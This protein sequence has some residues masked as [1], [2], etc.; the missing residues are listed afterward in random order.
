MVGLTGPAVILGCTNKISHEP[1]KMKVM[2]CRSP[3]KLQLSVELFLW[4]QSS[5]Q[6]LSG[7]SRCY[8]E[9]MAG[10]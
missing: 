10:L 1:G 8:H 4:Q 2:L 7:K 5:F 6:F 9:R 3:N